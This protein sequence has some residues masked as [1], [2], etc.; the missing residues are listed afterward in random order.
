MACYSTTTFSAIS[1]FPLQRETGSKLTLSYSLQALV[2]KQSAVSPETLQA[3]ASG[4]LASH[5]SQW[6]GWRVMPVH[7]V[8]LHRHSSTEQWSSHLRMPALE[9][10]KWH[11]EDALQ[12]TVLQL[13]V[14]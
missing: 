2:A 14:Q 3:S 4:V 10:M 13:H 11:R 8:Q 12:V 1:T 7:L 9:R 5:A 6:D